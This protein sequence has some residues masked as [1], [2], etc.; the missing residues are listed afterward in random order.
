MTSKTILV[1][2]PHPD[3]ESLGC[4]GTLLKH[5]AQGDDVHWLIGST[6]GENYTEEVR[7]LR[8][9]EI[10]DVAKKYGF[11]SVTQC[12]F[13]AA[14]LDQYPMGEVISKFWDAFNDIKPNIVYLPFQGD[15]H[16]DHHVVF[17]AGAACC[18]RF[19]YPW[20]ES[21]RTYETMSET[22]TALGLQPFIPNL[23]S[24]ITPF[25]EEKLEILK[26]YA[27]E[28][29]EFPF[30]RSEEA[31]RSQAALRGAAMGVKAAESFMLLQEVF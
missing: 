15:A 26:I 25:I 13:H 24:D 23:Y 8:A 31:I 27:S 30:P 16:T 18:K 9:K 3:D 1:V 10:D 7:S 4:G 14:K 20:I 28:I 2:A 19:R 11:S 17:S 5:A 21:V 12:P 29:G 22:D 6:M